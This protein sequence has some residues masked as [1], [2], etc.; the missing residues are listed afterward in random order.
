MKLLRRQFLHLAAGVAALPAVSR[1]A[2][3]QTYPTRPVHIIV[4][5]APAGGTD[6]FARLLGQ[7][8]SERFG[9]PFVIDNRPGASTNIATDAVARAPADG[10]TLLGTDAIAATNV[11]LYENLTFNFISDIAVVGM[12]RAPLIMMVHPARL[13]HDCSRVHHL[14]K[15]QSG[16]RGHGIG[17]SR[18]SEPPCRRAVQGDLHALR[19]C[20]PTSTLVSQKNFG[21]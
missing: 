4:G 12:I 2:R 18:K 8:L 21:Q 15:G 5:Y 13:R 10:Y 17:G 19:R 7:S 14:H 16:Q 3:A 11:A 9:Q 6:I 20:R 1:I